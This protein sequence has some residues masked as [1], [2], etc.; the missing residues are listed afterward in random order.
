MGTRHKYKLQLTRIERDGADLVPRRLAT[1]RERK[2]VWHATTA[3]IEWERSFLPF[4]LRKS[5][6]KSNTDFGG[7]EDIKDTQWSRELG[8]GRCRKKYAGRAGYRVV[9]LVTSPPLQ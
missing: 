5:T 6:Q 9:G 3:Y 7:V 8:A 4:F 1:W 2:Q